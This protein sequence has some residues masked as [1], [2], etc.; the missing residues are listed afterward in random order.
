MHTL[1]KTL[2][3]IGG[4]GLSASAMAELKPV[5][6]SEFVAKVKAEQ[7]QKD[8][9]VKFLAQDLSAKP[10]QS[11]AVAESVVTEAVATDIAPLL[12]AEGADIVTPAVDA[13]LEGEA[14]TTPETNTVAPVQAQNAGS[15][16]KTS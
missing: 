6:L 12:D 10:I 8:T 15:D 13:H 11:A 5:T 3:I 2:I 16:V 4:L 14:I 7:S 9:Q 1:L